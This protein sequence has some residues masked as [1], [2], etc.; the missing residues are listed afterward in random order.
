MQIV[1]HHFYH[2][3][4]SSYVALALRC[5]DWG[6]CTLDGKMTSFRH[7]ENIIAL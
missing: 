1:R 6:I 5:V 3:Y 2:L 7:S 4:A